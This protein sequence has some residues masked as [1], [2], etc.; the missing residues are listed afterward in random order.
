MTVDPA[1]GGGVS[2][3]RALTEGGRELLRAG[4]IGNELVVQEEYARHPRFG[5]GPW[6][7]TPT[8]TTAARSRDVR[9][10]VEVEHSPPARASPSGPTSGCSGT[11]SV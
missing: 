10:D 7:L 11:P 2:S 1:R 3:L 9:A 6:H 8:G 5:E 4:D